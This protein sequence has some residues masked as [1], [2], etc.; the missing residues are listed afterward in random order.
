M[1]TLCLDSTLQIEDT[2]IGMSPQ[3]LANGLYAPFKQ[4]D[5][6]SVGTGLGLSIVK[7]IANDI[8]AHLHVDSDLGEGTRVT[9]KLKAIF[10]TGERA[11]DA[12]SPDVRLFDAVKGLDMER[13][14]FYT[15]T[16]GTPRDDLL[17]T[18]ALVTSVRNTARSW[19]SCEISSGS[20]IVPAAKANI[21]AIT[22]SDLSRLAIDRPDQLSSMLADIASH[23]TQL[24]V[25]ARSVRPVSA[26]FSFAGSSIEPFFVSQA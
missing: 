13:L 3:F 16:R 14:H 4:V 2:G 17:G 7:Q 23:R 6:H 10:I 9:L 20:G 25:L 12:P 19:L 8:G 24:L 22:E 18:D 1:L 15:L 26:N 21:C 11:E 5:S